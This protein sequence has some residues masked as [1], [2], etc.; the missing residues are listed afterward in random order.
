WRARARAGLEPEV[1]RRHVERAL[2]EV[3]RVGEELVADRLPGRARRDEPCAGA[4]LDD[5]LLPA[6]PAREVLVAVLDVRRAGD[7]RR[8]EDRLEPRRVE[9]GLAG[10]E[11]EDVAQ[12]AQRQPA[13]LGA[14]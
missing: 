1:R 4:G 11:R 2:Q 9:P 6:D 12:R 5:D 3:L 13:A 14:Q 7:R 10:R 8:D